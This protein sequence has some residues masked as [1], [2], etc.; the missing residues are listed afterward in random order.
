M[1]LIGERFMVPFRIVSNCFPNKIVC[2]VLH[3]CHCSNCYHKFKINLR[4][5]LG[6]RPHYAPPLVERSKGAGGPE[7]TRGQVAG[8]ERIRGSL[9]LTAYV[10]LWLL[11]LTA[12]IFYSHMYLF[13]QSVS[14]FHDVVDICWGF[15]GIAR[16]IVDLFSK[17]AEN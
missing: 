3:V 6:S 7:W 15:Y 16:K 17:Y 8:G 14:T 1:S 4:F 5:N 12:D 9:T 10:L 2:D 13:D 11:S